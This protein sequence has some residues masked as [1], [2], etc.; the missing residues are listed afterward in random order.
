MIETPDPLGDVIYI[1]LR[2]REW[3]TGLGTF[4]QSER[5]KSDAGLRGNGK[6]R[7]AFGIRFQGLWCKFEVE[8]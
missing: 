1:T 4:L 7:D 5:L 2:F 8:P 3:S 6:K